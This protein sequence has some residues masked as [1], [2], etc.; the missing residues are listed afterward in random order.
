M[1]SRKRKEADGGA[2]PKAKRQK[3][4]EEAAPTK[5][6]KAGAHHAPSV[7]N[8]VTDPLTMLSLQYWAQGAQEKAAFDPKIVDQIFETELNP[9][10]LDL[11]RVMLLELSFYLEK[12]VFIPAQARLPIFFVRRMCSRSHPS[13]LPRY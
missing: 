7:Q 1:S 13:P 8:I 5:G 6:R 10:K 11:S 4:V 12:Y 9:Q 2:G 3:P